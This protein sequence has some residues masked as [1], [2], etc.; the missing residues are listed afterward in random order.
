MAEAAAAASSPEAR[1]P[2]DRVHILNAVAYV[3]N[4]IMTWASMMFPND[5]A[6]LSEKYQTVITPAGAAFS[7]WG[8]IFTWEL[9]FVVAQFL[10]RYRDS[11]LVATVSPW[12]WAAC[13]FQTLWTPFFALEWLELALAAMLCILISLAGLV[14]AADFVANLTF[15]EEALF[16]APFGVHCGWIIC[17]SAL[18]M[19]VVFVAA[20]WDQAALMAAAIVSLAVIFSQASLYAVALKYSNVL[21]PLVVAWASFWINQELDQ[22]SILLDSTREYYIPWTATS[23]EAMRSAACGL[24]VAALILAAVAVAMRVVRGRVVTGYVYAADSSQEEAATETQ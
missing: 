15:E 1:K 21:V 13:F 5:N 17:A 3:V 19:N 14:I 4:A 23:I 12:W 18:N 11:K 16:L 8:I 2:I 22:A 10:P 6:E 9:V 20:R 7:I 24:S